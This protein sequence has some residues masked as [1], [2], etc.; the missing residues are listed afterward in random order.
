[1]SKVKSFVFYTSWIDGGIEHLSG[2]ECKNILININKFHKGE[3]IKLESVGEKILWAQMQPLLES[4]LIKYEN[5][6][7]RNQT[8]GKKGGRPKKNPNN[9][10]GFIGNPNN[11]SV[12]QLNLVDDDVDDDV[13]VDDDL[14][15]NKLNI[16]I[17]SNKELLAEI[18]NPIH[19]IIYERFINEGYNE[20]EAK[21]NLRDLIRVTTEDELI[22]IISNEL[23]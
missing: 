8:N 10:L 17:N 1:M 2:D 11:P 6:T 16:K 12:T 3:E 15:L 5:I 18:E 20:N 4:N 14:R 23:E 9:P 13:D 21:E 7:E 19:Q 22:E